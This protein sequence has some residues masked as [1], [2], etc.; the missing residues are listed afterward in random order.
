MILIMKKWILVLFIMIFS[1]IITGCGQGSEYEGKWVSIIKSDWD[2]TK[3][4]Q[5]L[6]IKKN[7]ENY[8][9][10]PTTEQYRDTG[11]TVGEMGKKAIWN[12]VTEKPI[13]AT[14]KDGRLVID[15]FSNFTFVKNDGT[16][17]GSRGETYKKET[18]EEFTKLKAE[19]TAKFKEKHP[20][21]TINE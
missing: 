16:I 2:G 9:I 15:M 6:D 17:L 13:S 18:S 14:L 7:G 8:I 10:T 1:S 3:V 20:N 19:A 5:K 11:K 21:M 4:V 12:S